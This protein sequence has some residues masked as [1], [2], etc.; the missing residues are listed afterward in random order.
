MNAFSDISPL[1]NNSELLESFR[2]A[3]EQESSII[4]K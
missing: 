1:N 3:I 2:S 4:K